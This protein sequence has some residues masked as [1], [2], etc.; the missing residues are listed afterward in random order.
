MSDN[1]NL[2]GTIIAGCELIRELGRGN[3]GIVYL[4]NQKKLNRK[5]ACKI[6]APDLIDDPDFMDN[7]FSEAANAAKLSHRNIIQ[8]LDVGEAGDLKYFLM[9]FVDGYSLEHIRANTPE[10][11]S[12][13]FLLDI[14]IQLADAMDY[15]W[16]QHQMI[17]G[18]IKPGNILITNDN[19]LKVGDLGL[20][21]SSNGA[22][23]DPADVMITPLYAAPEV[24]TQ[25][26]TD[27]DQRSDI[28]SFGVMLYELA[29]GAAPFTGTVDE[30][31][32]SHIYKDPVPLFNMNPD[33]DKELASFIDRMLAKN[34]ADR[35]AD[36]KKV[37]AGL[38][39]IKR[40]LFP[41]ADVGESTVKSNRVILSKSTG[42]SWS[43]EGQK[44]KKLMEKMPWLLPTVLILTILV[45]IFYLLFDMG[46]FK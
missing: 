15:A 39:T 17:H 29:C 8:A 38:M 35:P 43:A 41:A 37:R 6:I 34:P 14:S 24:I 40:R 19:I 11:I 45:A 21:R 16:S 42:K 23:G 12:T 2:N 27:P 25:Q 1:N 36:W 20:A 46:L 28:Y 18:D 7:L 4:A 5:V 33:M 26:A 3:N 22:T 13:A 30:I 9:E 10:R 32:Q 31:L 44:E